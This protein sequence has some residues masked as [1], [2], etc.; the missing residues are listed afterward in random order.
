MIRRMLERVSYR[1][2]VRVIRNRDGVTPYLSRFYLL[3]GPRKGRWSRWPFNMMLHKFHTGDDAGELHNHP[4]QWAVSLILAG[5]Y[6]EDVR[7]PDDTI[8]RR[9]VRPLQ[10]NLIT[11]R[12]FHRVDLREQD[13]W[14]L[15]ITGPKAD[16]EGSWGFWSPVMGYLPWQ[17]FIARRRS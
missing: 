9:E 11:S 13:C 15:F 4:W 2:R 14:T 10:L 16:D 3:G 17:E 12:T 8:V 5:G 7:L 6:W 1:L